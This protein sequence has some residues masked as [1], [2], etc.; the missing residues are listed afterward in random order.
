MRDIEIIKSYYGFTT[1]QAQKYMKAIS[2]KTIDNI[3]KS[4]EENSK[5][6]FYND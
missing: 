1:Q 2:Q 5:K 3:R 4:F 6:A